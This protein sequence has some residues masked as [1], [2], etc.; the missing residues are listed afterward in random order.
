LVTFT[1]PESRIDAGIPQ[2]S[3]ISPVLYLFYNADLLAI[4]DDI[5]LRTSST[6]F[7]DDV[8]I[9]T[10]SKSR[11]KL[12]P[13]RACEVYGPYSLRIRPNPFHAITKTVCSEI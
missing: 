8:N 2:G 12:P 6:G 5:R 11:G 1:L 7:L 9:L 13:V 10:H 4:S 3:P